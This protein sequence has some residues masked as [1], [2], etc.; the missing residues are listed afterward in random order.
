MYRAFLK[1]AAIAAGAALAVAACGG[2][3]GPEF[4]RA[5]VQQITKTTQEF[6]AAYNAKDPAK[7]AGFFSGN[8][9]VMPPNA[10]TLHGQDSIKGYYQ[11]RFAEGASDLT[12]DPKTISGSGPLAYLSGTYS[13]VN[14]PANGPERRD[15]GK[16]L[17]IAR[18]LAGRWLYECQMWSS[19]LPPVA[20]PQ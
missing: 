20:P 9:M 11:T 16:F 14:R 15:R 19:D 12:I 13:F 17:W 1:A 2:P 18:S 7:V 4:G 6:V 8:G 3:K 5:E 10:S